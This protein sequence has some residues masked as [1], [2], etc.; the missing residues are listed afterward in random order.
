VIWVTKKKSKPFR[1][2]QKP[3]Q[4][5]EKPQP[6]FMMLK[7]PTVFYYQMKHFDLMK[8]DIL[9]YLNARIKDTPLK[10]REN[11]LYLENERILF[12][13][14]PLAVS[15]DA[16]RLFDFQSNLGSAALRFNIAIDK[17]FALLGHD[18]LI[19]KGFFEQANIER[20]AQHPIIFDYGTKEL[21]KN[22]PLCIDRD[23]SYS[24]YST[25]NES[26]N[27]I[28]ID[29]FACESEFFKEIIKRSI[30]GYFYKD[31]HSVAIYQ[32]IYLSPDGG[33]QVALSQL[34]SNYTSLLDLLTN[35]IDFVFGINI[36]KTYAS[37]TFYYKN[38]KMIPSSS[39][40]SSIRVYWSNID[41]MLEELKSKQGRYTHEIRNRIKYW[42]SFLGKNPT[43]HQGRNIITHRGR[44]PI[45][46]KRGNESGIYV[47]F[48]TDTNKLK[49]N[50]PRMNDYFDAVNYCISRYS[51][52]LK[53][54]NDFYGL[55]LKAI[56]SN[57]TIFRQIYIQE[58]IDNAK[59]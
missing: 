1:Q 39:E 58:I 50:D 55:L 11:E 29:E 19:R 51:V 10:L 36:S 15:Q 37:K 18:Y 44:I 17:L 16:E 56:T 20:L 34:L 40:P 14:I 35:L 26:K 52:I 53:L 43:I 45:E 6:Q 48:S 54:Y 21:S 8:K 5:Q 38:N 9:D 4:Q 24:A 25:Q 32:K 33:I 12:E 42:Q 30:S 46:Y 47:C 3:T 13:T 23:A 41:L 57:E 7:Q 49:E 28:I 22:N 31:M 27:P 2:A 59:V